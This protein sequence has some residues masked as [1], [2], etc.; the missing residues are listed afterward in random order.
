MRRA[1]IA[2]DRKRPDEALGISRDLG[3]RSF[4]EQMQYQGA[5]FGVTPH[6]SSSREQ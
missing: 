6:R 4:L 2:S 3:Q 5:V 1:M